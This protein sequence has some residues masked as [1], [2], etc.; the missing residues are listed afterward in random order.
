MSVNILSRPASCDHDSDI[1][2]SVDDDYSDPSVMPLY[3]CGCRAVK[4]PVSRIYRPST[5]DVI[6]LTC[7]SDTEPLE[8]DEEMMS[9]DEIVEFVD[10]AEQRRRAEAD[11]RVRTWHA[12]WLERTRTEINNCLS[13]PYKM[14]M[15]SFQS[16]APMSWGEFIDQNPSVVVDVDW[17]LMRPRRDYVVPAHPMARYREAFPHD[18][19]IDSYGYMLNYHT[20]CSACSVR[21]EIVYE[22]EHI[23]GVHY[24][25]NVDFDSDGVLTI[26][27][28]HLSKHWLASRWGKVLAAKFQINAGGQNA[29]FCGKCYKRVITVVAPANASNIVFAHAFSS[30]I[31]S[32]W[33]DVSQANSVEI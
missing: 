24:Y 3:S 9:V 4:F 17:V 10:E 5:P 23:H 30:Y 7:D 16:D 26:G 33:L 8:N 6:D 32:A 12:S 28:D 13:E 19:H 20:Y 27:C 15:H 11:Q 22:Y 21:P 14:T 29:R 31:G 2:Y 25:M 1:V 18:R